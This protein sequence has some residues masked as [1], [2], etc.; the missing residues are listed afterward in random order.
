MAKAQ[1]LLL[2]CV[3]LSPLIT[4]K[5][6]AQQQIQLFNNISEAY[7]NKDYT[8]SLQLCNEYLSKYQ[9]D[10]NVI[11]IRAK[12]KYN[13]G[14]FTPAKADLDILYNL[15]KVKHPVLYYRGL[16]LVSMEDYIPARKSFIE[17]ISLNNKITAYHYN[18]GLLYILTNNW[19]AAIEAFNEVLLLEPNNA[20]ALINK[21]FAYSMKQMFYEAL[22]D[23]NKALTYM[24]DND[25]LLV[26]RG[27][28]LI[29]LRKNNQAIQT[30][31]KAI[32]INPQNHHAYYNIGRA[33]FENK[34]FYKAKL[35][36]DTTLT[37]KPEME[38]ALFNRA[39][40]L[41][42]LSMSNTYIACEDFKKAAT[43]GYGEA[44]EY[45][46]KYCK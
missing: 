5:L 27:M 20:D 1:F 39:V 4:N 2:L 24:P 7:I 44:W 9:G 11:F 19:K 12:N 41:L 3:Y 29:S 40:S 33:Y 13:L 46:K 8:L 42:E 30:L 35:Y 18:L 26:K 34:D 38:I 17:A 22:Q 37:I 25:D 28:V 6:Y 32:A 36:F 23:Y 31:K 14:Y 15:V 45:L 21:G 16:C 10:T 43:L